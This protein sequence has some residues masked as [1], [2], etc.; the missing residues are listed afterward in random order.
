MQISLQNFSSLVAN[1]S[2]S[3]QGASATVLDVTVGSVLRA[4]LEASASVGLWLQYLILQVLSM[5]R[6]SSSTGADADSWVNDFGMSR[7]PAT[8]ATGVV[9]MAS[10]NPSAQAAVIS[11]GMTVRLSDGSQTFTVVNGPYVRAIGQASVDVTVQAQTAGVIGNVQAGAVNMLGTAISGID[12][13]SNAAP[14]AGGASAETDAALRARF[15]TYINTRAQATEQAIVYAAA[16][17]GPTI[18]VAIQENVTATGAVL[19]GNVNVVVDDGSGAPPA[20]VLT[21]VAAAIDPI[22]PVGT[23]IT[24]VAPSVIEVSMSGMI[25]VAAGI[26]AAPVIATATTALESFV[27]GLSVGQLLPYSRLMAVLYASS[28]LIT[29]VTGLTVNGSS[30][31]VGGMSGT[32]VR[33]QSVSLSVALS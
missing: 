27:N 13:V 16:S 25:S 31:D 5:T 18:S 6:L 21:A 11:N 24:V 9:T 8:A 22:R 23:T 30:A 33:C 15:V 17:V 3:V 2:A 4:I 10:F 14:F 12:T 1:M 19:P 26:D 32:V 7:L 20:S 28:P 29:N